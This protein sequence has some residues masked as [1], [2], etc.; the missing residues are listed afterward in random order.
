M[1]NPNNTFIKIYRS[2]LDWGWHKYPNTLSLFVHLI[3]LANIKDKPFGKITVKRGQY[4][5]SIADLSKITGL[6]V[7]QVRTSL[8]RLKETNEVAIQT[9][10]KGSIIT[11]N[12]YDKFQTRAN[13]TANKGQA[14]GKPRAN[15]GQLLKNIYNNKLLYIKE[16]K[17]G[18]R[19]KA[20]TLSEIQNF[21][22]EQK[23]NVDYQK[24]YDYYNKRNWQINNEPIDNW[25]DLVITWSKK[26]HKTYASGAYDGVPTINKEEFEKWKAEQG[27]EAYE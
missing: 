16:G 25:K 9:N 18:R 2:L 3:I 21:V 13:K 19:E 10:S 6:S 20:P 17:K 27:G 14:E 12:N 23:L 11:I 24:F 1:A 26:E 5:T 22:A 15:E 8:N 7:K 4:V